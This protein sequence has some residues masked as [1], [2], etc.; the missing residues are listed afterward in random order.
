MSRGAMEMNL[1]DG[2]NPF[3][4]ATGLCIPHKALMEA[5]AFVARKRIRISSSAARAD[6]LSCH[7]HAC[8]IGYTQAAPKSLARANQL[9]R[10]VF[11]TDGLDHG[12]QV[13]LSWL[14]VA[15]CARKFVVAPLSPP[16]LRSGQDTVMM[17]ELTKRQ[18]RGNVDNLCK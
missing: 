10:N 12:E 9:A 6:I 16:V 17:V 2:S 15:S 13:V 14:A 3:F 18:W 8:C 7:V 11:C 4:V 5:P 1:Q